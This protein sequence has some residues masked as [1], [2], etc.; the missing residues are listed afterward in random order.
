MEN[1]SGSFDHGPT[2]SFPLFSMRTFLERAKVGVLRRKEEY[3]VNGNPFWFSTPVQIARKSRSQGLKVAE[4]KDAGCIP[5][6]FIVL[7]HKSD[8]FVMHEFIA[9]SN[10]CSGCLVDLQARSGASRGEPG[11]PCPRNTDTAFA[12]WQ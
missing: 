7:L 12:V 3:H 11:S 9:R 6:G 8:H 10:V 2:G 4:K 5:R 1:A